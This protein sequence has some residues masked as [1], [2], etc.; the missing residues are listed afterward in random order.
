MSFDKTAGCMGVLAVEDAYRLLG[1]GEKAALVDVRTQA[2]WALVGVPDLSALGK[3]PIFQEWQI[4]PS[5]ELAPNFASRLSDTLAA[6]GA[7]RSSPVLFL[8]RSGARSLAAAVAMTNAGWSHCY[9]V[10]GGFEGPLDDKQRRGA[11]DG[12]KARGLPWTQS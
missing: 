4:Y 9:N 8:C 3:A 7:D 11:A 5:M 6:Q 1:E 12:W 10:A 2:E